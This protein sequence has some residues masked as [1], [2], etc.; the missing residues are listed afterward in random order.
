MNI[1][2]RLADTNPILF[3]GAMGTIL[4]QKGLLLAGET[5][6]PLNIREPEAIKDIHKSYLD[7]G[8]EII[9][10]NTFGANRKKMAGSSY[11]PEEVISAGVARAKEAA[12]GKGFVALDVGPLGELLEPMG[13]LSFEEAYDVFKE[14]IVCGAEAGADLVLIETMTD[15]YEARAALLA[16]KENSDLP[17]FV[18]MSYEATGRTFTGCLP[19]CMAAV[20]EGMGAD[21]IGFNCSVGIQDMIP[22]VETL[23]QH[24][25]LPI[26]VQANAGLPEQSVDGKVSYHN[27][28]GDFAKY[29]RRLAKMG[30]KVLG[31]C[32][33]T[34]PETIQAVKEA[35]T[36]VNITRNLPV[37]PPRVCSPTRMVQID[38]VKIVGERI[39]PTGKKD[40]KEALRTGDMEFILRRAIEQEEAGADILDVNV[41]LPDLDEV[42]VMERVLKSLQGVTDLPL[43]IDSSDPK[44]LERAL[45]LYHG[46]AIV[47]SVNGEDTQLDAVLPLVKK[48]GAAVIGLTLDEKGIPQKA[49]ERFKIAEKIVA[50]AEA[51]GISRQN[52][53]I[54]ALTLTASAE[55]EAVVETLQTLKLVKERL[56]VCTV[57]GVSNISF[58]LPCREELN[59]SFLTLAMAHG[60][61]LA[62]INPNVKSMVDAIASFRVL[63]NKDKDAS[64]YIKRFSNANAVSESKDMPAKEQSFKALIR[65]GLKREAEEMIQAMLCDRAGYEL[66]E[67]E[68]VP[69]L[70]AVGA[71]YEAGRL[72]LPQLIAAAEAAKGAMELIKSSLAVHDANTATE[73]VIILATVKGDIHDIGKNIVKVMLQNYGYQVI[74]LGRDV[75]PQSI[76][77]EAQMHKAC[78]VGLSALMT[79]T[80]TNMAET[81]RLLKESLPAVKTMVGGAVLTEEYAKSIDADYYAKDAN[82]AVSVAKMVF[83]D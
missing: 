35:L 55:Q 71:D 81:I 70:D 76:V 34:T 32:C 1:R 38:D 72:F 69:A 73:K 79:T 2:E 27:D 21:A 49:E 20:L 60:L 30:C 75:A 26:I 64:D 57:L 36:D 54:D 18:T 59:R 11:T 45:R 31:G 65:R 77:D 74:D 14:V 61:D 62:I 40:M 22:L 50:R 39:N 43:Q 15:L 68:I 13:S 58:G 83:G 16:A 5:P 9:T 52:I 3:D 33:G 47:N 6:E 48:Y 56:G 78:L 7:A 67:R 23:A 66:I 80:V 19:E 28:D 44:V 25:T 4:Q 10:T 17:V 24:T 51:Y 63:Y 82:Q 46:K 8:A 53:C 37:I 12:S 42:K 41:G 29:S